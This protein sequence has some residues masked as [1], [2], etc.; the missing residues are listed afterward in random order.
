MKKSFIF[1]TSLLFLSIFLCGCASKQKQLK[2]VQERSET[3]IADI[4]AF[5][6][7]NLHLYTKESINQ[8]KI[9]DFDVYFSP[10]TNSVFLNLKLGINVI[11]LEY[12]YAERKNVYEAA[13]RYLYNYE[14]GLIVDEKATSKNA[15]YKGEVPVSWGVFGLTHSVTTKYR[16][17]TEYLWID[18][19]YFR[20]RYEATKD[21]KEDSSS[22]AFSIYISPS[23][24][25]TIYEMCN[26][27]ALEA[28]V[29]EILVDAEAW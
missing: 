6:L 25:E 1:I 22:P 18:R 2:P 27:A 23:Q 11:Q 14:N 21:T 3:F 15:Y 17:H 19:P 28:K 26:Q 24:W 5:F 16:I 20:L 10:R 9:S 12:S 7:G 29:D 13:Q 8:P 4:N